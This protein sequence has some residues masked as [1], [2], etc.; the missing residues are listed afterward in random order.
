[1]KTND[2]SI[3]EKFNQNKDFNNENELIDESVE[4]S[5]L[6]SPKEITEENSDDDLL[7][8]MEALKEIV[9]VG[10]DVYY[11]T[12]SSS[13]D[14]IGNIQKKFRNILKY[15]FYYIYIFVEET[16]NDLIIVRNLLSIN[17]R[18]E[19]VRNFIDDLVENIWRIQESNLLS[20]FFEN[21]EISIEFKK[22]L[23]MIENKLDQSMF[24]LIS[25]KEQFINMNNNASLN[26]HF[27]KIIS[28]NILYK[29]IHLL[30]TKNNKAINLN[31]RSEMSSVISEKASDDIHKIVLNL[32]IFFIT[33]NNHE[34]L[35]LKS[36]STNDNKSNITLYI[37][38]TANN[39]HIYIEEDAVFMNSEKI[40]K[41]SNNVGYKN[42]YIEN[43]NNK[44]Y[45][46]FCLTKHLL[47][48]DQIEAKYLIHNI[49]LLAIKR[50]VESYKGYFSM[51]FQN[52][53]NLR[54]HI[55]LPKKI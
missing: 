47:L 22:L 41:I 35:N 3:I 34:N 5:I 43:W 6:D 45:S 18:T 44:D 29:Y 48:N 32:I 28:L 39:F 40:K 27:Q 21:R 54:Y 16:L 26:N 12:I 25:L 30:S 36:S 20:H 52:N 46:T 8:E 2:Y 42:K 33:Q 23:K 50:T 11:Y 1:M 4:S 53:I 13:I 14:L 55:I 10:T 24:N 31:I 15:D 37:K 19:L 7:L 17:T 9:S 38:Q 51:S 49:M